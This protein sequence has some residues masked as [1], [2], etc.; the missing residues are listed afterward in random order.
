MRLLCSEAC[1]GPYIH[2]PQLSWGGAASQG[3]HRIQATHSLRLLSTKTR[4]LART[5]GTKPFWAAR[6]L[7]LSN[8]ELARFSAS[9]SWPWT[10]WLYDGWNPWFFVLFFPCVFLMFSSEGNVLLAAT[11]WKW[12]KEKLQSAKLST[13]FLRLLVL[14]FGRRQ[15]MM[16]FPTRW[17]SKCAFVLIEIEM[18]ENFFVL[19]LG[20][21]RV[22]V[23]AV[24]VASGFFFFS[25]WWKKSCFLPRFEIT[26]PL[27][28]SRVQFPVRVPCLL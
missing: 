4:P 16:A 3:F 23:V 26:V 12:L 9:K 8:Y 22:V 21:R 18:G 6:L 1:F 27:S 20:E 13:P 11:R 15:M 5:F 17:G 19:F 10:C 7:R 28:L 24:V 14:R 2:W 25:R